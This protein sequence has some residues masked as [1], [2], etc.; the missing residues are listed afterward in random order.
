MIHLLHWHRQKTVPVVRLKLT[1][2]KKPACGLKKG[3]FN[4]KNGRQFDI[5]S[6]MV[7][8]LKP[9]TY[10][11]PKNTIFVKKKRLDI[12]FSTWYTYNNVLRWDC[13]AKLSLS[14]P[15][16][17]RQKVEDRKDSTLEKHRQTAQVV[18]QNTRILSIHSDSRLHIPVPADW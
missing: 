4:S 3:C 14:I 9:R 1:N 10:K 11:I 8:T 7:F 13:L 2:C 12:P 15:P 18:R 17:F 6:R 16:P 5:M